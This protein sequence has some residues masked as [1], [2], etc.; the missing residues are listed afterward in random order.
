MVRDESRSGRWEIYRGFRLGGIDN[1]IIYTR[2][3][4]KRG[5]GCVYSFVLFPY[6]YLDGLDMYPFARLMVRRRMV[7]AIRI[8]IYRSMITDCMRL[9]AVVHIYRILIVAFL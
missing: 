7:S 6:L 2:R 1:D 5:C 3:T 4:N 9:S 8:H